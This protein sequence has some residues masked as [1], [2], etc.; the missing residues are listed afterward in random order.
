MTTKTFIP[1][2]ILRWEDNSLIFVIDLTS[3]P[4]FLSTSDKLMSVGVPNTLSKSSTSDCSNKLNI[5]PPL[6]SLII[7]VILGFCSDTGTTKL[8]KSCNA[9]RSPSIANVGIF[10]L[11]AVP[12]AVATTPSMPLT[13]RFIETVTSPF[14]NAEF[15]SG[16]VSNSK[17]LAAR[18]E[19]R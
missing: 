5:P 12:I 14:E 17:S 9:A 6:L 4:R 19:A 16:E 8:A 13:P 18:L 10:V 11:K 3:A 2:G 15:I 7:K 1:L